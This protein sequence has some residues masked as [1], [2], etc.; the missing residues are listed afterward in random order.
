MLT[1]KKQPGLRSRTPLLIGGVALLVLI[2]G[3]YLLSLVA[4]PTVS[5]FVK[6]PVNA[7]DI[8]APKKQADRIII[9]TIGVDVHYGSNGQASLDQ[10]A[11]WRYPER[12]DP[13]KGGNFII[14][15]HRFSIQP[16]PGKTI[17]KSPFYHIGKLKQ[18][19][20]I[21]VDYNGARYGYAIS[22]LFNVKPDQTEIEA[23]LPDDASRLTLYSCDLGGSAEG[24]VVLYAKPLGEVA[25]D[26]P[27]HR[28]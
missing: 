24:R 18:G 19:D 8:A 28:S 6:K 11:W 25:T 23:P 21:L 20:K 9:P 14:A 13:Q 17:E 4:A 3:L 16:T 22:K 1:I 26:T 7:A 10:G 12:G 27:S 15:A 2:A 5:L